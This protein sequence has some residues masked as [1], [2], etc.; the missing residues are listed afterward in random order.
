M[1]CDWNKTYFCNVSD[2]GSSA[3]FGNVSEN[4][5]EQKLLMYQMGGLNH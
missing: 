5:S 4:E 2:R 3:Y 1:S